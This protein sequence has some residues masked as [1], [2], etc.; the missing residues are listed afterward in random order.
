VHPLHNWY[1][2][3]KPMLSTIFF[4]VG[5]APGVCDRPTEAIGSSLK[6]AESEERAEG[7]SQ[8]TAVTQFGQPHRIA[9]A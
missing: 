5:W 7:S 6:L 1:Y 9:F 4:A 2:P 8:S 3:L